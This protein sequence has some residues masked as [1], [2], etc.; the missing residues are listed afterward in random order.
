[1]SFAH[2]PTGKVRLIGVRVHPDGAVPFFQVKPQE[3]ANR[4]AALDDVSGKLARDVTAP[5]YDAPTIEQ[6]VAVL[7]QGLARIATE[8]AKRD[9]PVR[10]AVGRILQTGGRVSIDE[11]VSGASISGRQLERRF[12]SEVGIGPKVLCR[13]LRFQQVFQALD[14][15]SGS[16]ATVAA[17]CGYYD[18]SHLIRDFQEFAGAAPASIVHESGALTEFF[19]RKHRASLFSNTRA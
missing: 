16:W 18:Q 10:N 8:Y 13:I 9:A 4:Y 14:R 2:W 3:L 6:Q 5:V 17:D 19:T 1:M 15:N 11:L 12:L 7:E